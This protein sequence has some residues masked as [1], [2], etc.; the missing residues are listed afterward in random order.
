MESDR[1]GLFSSWTVEARPSLLQSG[2]V[3]LPPRRWNAAGRPV[4]LAG[5]G[6]RR[7]GAPFDLPVPGGICPPQ[8]DLPSEDVEASSSSRLFI[9]RFGPLA[10]EDAEV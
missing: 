10:S 9:L 2:G 7:S 8:P 3:R 4:L 1:R 5:A 6:L